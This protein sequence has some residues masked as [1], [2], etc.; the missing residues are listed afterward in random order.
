M[1]GM[2]SIFKRPDEAQVIGWYNWAFSV[3]NQNNPFHPSKGGNFFKEKNNNED[4]IWLAGITATTEP[5]HKPSQISNVTAVLAGAEARAVYNDGDGKATR[6]L[7]P[8]EPRKIMINQADKRDL[9]VP[10]STEIATETKYPKLADKLGELAQKIIDREDDKNGDPPAFIEFV[11]ANQKRE[12]KRGKQLKPEFRVNTT[13]DQLHVPENNVFMLPAGDGAAGVSDY[14]I[15][16]KRM[17]DDQS[18]DVPDPLKPGTNIL[19]FG[20]TGKFFSYTVEYQ[21]EFS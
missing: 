2:A 9:Y 6:N 7:P 11:D 13:I 17:P 1:S 8:I 3:T 15:I 12:E 21:I 14:A 5:A 18:Q 19:K 16:L 20:V 10:I 4:I